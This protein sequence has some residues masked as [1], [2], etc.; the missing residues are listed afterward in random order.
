LRPFVVAVFDLS[1]QLDKAQ[2]RDVEFLGERLGRV[3]IL[4][5]F[6]N[7]IFGGAAAACLQELNVVDHQEIKA[8]VGA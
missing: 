3:V 6:L 2:D 7:A 4:G 5:D 8:R 1:R